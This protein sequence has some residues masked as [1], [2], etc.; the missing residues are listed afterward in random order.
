[1]GSC[2]DARGGIRRAEVCAVVEHGLRSGGFSASAGVALA[3]KELDFIHTSGVAV[4]IQAGR[5]AAN[6]GAMFAVLAAAASP[7][8]DWLVLAVPTAYKGTTVIDP[9]L[10][11]LDDLR[12]SPGIRLDLQGVLVVGY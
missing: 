5:A 2:R 9:V 3:A 1:M 12:S 8:V 7:P 10:R 11:E 6:H 4:S